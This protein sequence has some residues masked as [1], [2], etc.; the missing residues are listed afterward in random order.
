MSGPRPQSPSAGGHAP[1]YRAIRWNM[2]WITRPLFGIVL[3]GIAILVLFSRPEFFAGMVILITILAAYEWHRMVSL[4]HA[5][6]IETA[7]T[8][9][10]AALAV[11]ALLALRSGWPALLIV[12]AGA[13]ISAIVARARGQ[14]PV[15][16]ALGVV[17]L[18]LPALALV[19]LQAFPNRGALVIVGLF[20]IVWATDTGALIFG[21]LIGGPRMAPVLSPSKTW[22]G[23]IGGSVTAALVFGCYVWLLGGTLWIAAMFGLIFS[24]V[25]HIG[26]LFESFVKRR[27][28]IK[29]SG[30]LIPGHGGVL[31]RM[32]STIFASVALA[33][34]VF[35][36]HFNLLFG[37][38]S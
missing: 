18:G 7:L 3:A 23:T 6:R 22:A 4:G 13:V 5:F 28:G 33:L 35:L 29:N 36:A 34:L 20:L 19:S 25:A 26:D 24:A 14:N 2:D 32:D 31:D 15:W 37:I 38:A 9:V 21:N 16:Q 8:S 30:S 12:A 27:F 11:V 1:G 17:Y 10:T